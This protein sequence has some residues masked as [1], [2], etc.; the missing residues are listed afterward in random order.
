MVLLF[1][2]V[3]FFRW[4]DEFLL[5]DGVAR[6]PYCFHVSESEACVHAYVL[7]K[8]AKSLPKI[9]REREQTLLLEGQSKGCSA[10]NIGENIIY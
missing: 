1:V 8:I 7:P 6:R 5:V 4:I 10:L 3:F 9:G 2:L